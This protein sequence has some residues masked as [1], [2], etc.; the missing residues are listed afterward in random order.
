MRHK[1][2]ARARLEDGAFIL[3][4]ALVASG[5]LVALVSLTI[6]VF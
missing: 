3:A 4:L 5:A 6:V 2:P 1:S